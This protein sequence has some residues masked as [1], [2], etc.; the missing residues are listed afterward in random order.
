MLYYMEEDDIEKLIKRA[1]QDKEEDAVQELATYQKDM[2]KL[3]ERL[4]R[5]L[6]E[7]DGTIRPRG[8]HHSMGH[9]R[10]D[11][12]EDGVLQKNE[13]NMQRAKKREEERQQ[14]EKR[15]RE[16]EAQEAAA[17]TVKAKPASAPTGIAGQS[18][19]A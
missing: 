5:Q 2:E 6:E 1:Q 3:D 11:E 14:A 9:K 19:A 15:K 12:D 17:N 7:R 8:L 13:A 18:S 10:R 4:W 16:Q